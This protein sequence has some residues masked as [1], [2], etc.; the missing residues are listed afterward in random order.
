MKI[1][2]RCRFQIGLLS[3]FRLIF[4][5]FYIKVK[6]CKSLVPELDFKT[7]RVGHWRWQNV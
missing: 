7:G 3:D 1:C 2:E 6:Q 5:C 4:V